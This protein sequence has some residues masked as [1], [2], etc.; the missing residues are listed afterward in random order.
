MQM[1]SVKHND[2]SN[3]ELKN[4]I[5]FCVEIVANLVP[6][7]DSTVVFIEVK[8]GVKVVDYLVTNSD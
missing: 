4:L 5:G 2:N 1:V 8:A 7:V 3:E 6:I